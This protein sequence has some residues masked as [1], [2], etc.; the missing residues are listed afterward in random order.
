VCLT[1]TDCGVSGLTST[2]FAPHREK[3]AMR[4]GFAKGCL[5]PLFYPHRHRWRQ[6]SIPR[7]SVCLKYRPMDSQGWRSAKSR[8]TP[9]GLFSHTARLT[10]HVGQRSGSFISR[11]ARLPPGL[12]ARLA[13][14]MIASYSGTKV[15]ANVE[16]T[17]ETPTGNCHSAR[18]ACTISTFVQ[19]SL[20]TRHLATSSIASVRSTATML[21]LG[22]D[23]PLHV[24][25]IQTRP[26]AQL[27]DLVAGSK[28]QAPISR[29][30]G[31]G[32]Y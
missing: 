29:P 26:A 15:I 17:A 28:G 27:D 13:L 18:S 32:P 21:S 25:K 12:N 11:T 10:S 19:C 1:F 3:Y 8:L 7:N 30:V 9:N 23:D 5:K 14:S 31:I 4:R 16:Y 2:P 6:S 20:A 24:L 22:T